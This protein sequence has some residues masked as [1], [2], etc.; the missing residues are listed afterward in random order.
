MEV[1]LRTVEGAVALVDDVVDPAAIE[2]RTKRALGEVPL[3]VAA[4][5]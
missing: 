3:L 2:R 1:D 5:L 4:E